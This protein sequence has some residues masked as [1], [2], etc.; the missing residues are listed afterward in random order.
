MSNHQI[1][2]RPSRAFR[3]AALGPRLLFRLGLGWVAGHHLLEVTHRGRRS[4]R[5]YHTIVEVVRCEPRTRES[6]A[7]AG[8]GGHTDWFRNL[9]AAP[10]LRVQTGRHRYVP[11]QRMLSPAEVEHEFAAYIRKHPL[12]SRYL[13]GPLMGV[14]MDTSD[15]A[16]RAATWFRGVAFRPRSVRVQ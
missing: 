12:A 9:Q 7:F 3:L 4:G 2:T 6:I 11:E 1:P 14:R 15:D 16:R 5:V 13:F 10:A 8:W